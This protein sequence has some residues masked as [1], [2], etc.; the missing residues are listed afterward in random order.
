MG[1]PMQSPLVWI[2]KRHA[3]NPANIVEVFHEAGGE[4]PQSRLRPR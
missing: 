1:D 4:V 3:I 2:G